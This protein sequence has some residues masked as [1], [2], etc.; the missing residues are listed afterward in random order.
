L[1][2]ARGAR[3]R[4]VRRSE[5]DRLLGLTSGEKEQKQRHHDIIHTLFFIV[6]N[7]LTKRGQQWIDPFLGVDWQGPTNLRALQLFC[8]I[9]VLPSCP[10]IVGSND[11]FGKIDPLS[12]IDIESFARISL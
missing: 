12:T 6:V 9:C 4:S 11:R 8:E 3:S 7:N 5:Q 1:T 10:L 2:L